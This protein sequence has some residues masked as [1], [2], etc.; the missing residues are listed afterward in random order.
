M[1]WV[2]VVPRRVF[3]SHTS[4]L[5]RWPVGHSFVAAAERAISRAGDAVVEMAYFTAQDRPPAQVVQEKVRAAQVYVLIAGFRYGMP[6]RDRPEV[7]Y[8]ELEF[9][10]ATEAG[11]PRLVFVL[12]EET[13]GPSGL[14]VDGD[15]G[16]RQ[17]AFR[18]RL[19]ECGLTLTT[20]TT[21][22]GLSEA[23]FHA[24]CELPRR[25]PVGQ[26]VSAAVAMRT[27]P[28]DIASF[29]GRIEEL[30][31]VVGAVTSR[32]GGVVGIHAIDGMAGVGKTALAVRAAHE[33]AQYFPDGQLF[34]RLHAHTP[35]QRPVDPADVLGTLLLARGVA[36]QQIPAGLAAR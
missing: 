12:G 2:M 23:L 20:V 17:A 9:Q 10:E 33:I 4:E 27:L 19:A 15:Y 31:R 28:R 30:S 3:V 29:T 1:L 5:G 24:L 25:E 35:G 11:L 34:V 8:T 26:G 6:V 7:S 36:P 22:E 32:A 21:P 16:A 13:E 18:A 14:F